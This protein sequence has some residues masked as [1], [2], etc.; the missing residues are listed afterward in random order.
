ALASVSPPPGSVE[1]KSAKRATAADRRRSRFLNVVLRTHENKEVR[2]YDD[3][4]KD[5]TV[6][7]NFM[8][9]ACKGN[10]TLT[11][12]NLVQVQKALGQSVGRDSFFYSISV[13]PV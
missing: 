7:I 11:T 13:H 12:A 5:K 10:C 6:L 3:L 9:T 2:F 4:L 1:E 8:Y